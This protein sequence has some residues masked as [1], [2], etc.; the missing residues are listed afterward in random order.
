[1]CVRCALRF[2]VNVLVDVVVE[3]VKSVGCG[4]E[5]HWRSRLFMIE[6]ERIVTV[7]K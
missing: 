5:E 3:C 7:V 2:P 1:M 6:W 4:L